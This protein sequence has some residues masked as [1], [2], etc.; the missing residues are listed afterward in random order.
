MENQLL[1]RL[2][3]GEAISGRE[4]LQLTVELSIPAIL[5]QLSSIIM[6]YIDAAMV[7]HLSSYDSAAIG[8][9]SSSTWLLGG[10]CTAGSLGFTV[11]VAH[12]IGAKEGRRARQTVRQ[13]IL[14]NLGIALLL[15]TAGVLVH[16]RLPGWL[17]G[18]EEIRQGAS[19]YFLIFALSL[20]MVILNRLVTGLLQCSGNMKVPSMMHILMCFL[21]VV[22]NALLIFDRLP[23]RLG[24]RTLTLPGAGLGVAGAALG[25]ALAQTCAVAG[26]FYFLF[27]R[28]AELKP[29]RGEKLP[30]SGKI[31]REALRI[32]VPVGVEQA[33]LSSAY[34][35]GTLIVAP[36]GTTAIAANSLSITAESL[37]YMPGYG[38][39][40]AA[41]TLIGQSIGARRTDLTGKIAWMI[42]GL[43]SGIM[44][45]S[46]ALMF[47]AAPLMISL[48]SPDP[49]VQALGAQVLRIE[50]FAE[51]L[52]GASIVATGVLRGA[53]DTL[54][55]SIM[56]LFSMWAVRI[57]LGF[58]LSRFMG[59]A[60]YWTA[61]CTE[62]CVRG[63]IYLLRLRFGRWN[64]GNLS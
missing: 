20:P 9:V 8:L 38:I 2:R 4:L 25:T 21:D 61:M 43:G 32:G 28:S 36:L 64:R 18:A 56:N 16:R 35:A 15:L 42:T 51:P 14:V 27:F 13:G 11:Q 46:G 6:Q 37:C 48:L 54:I 57:P 45:C 50:A 53:G 22:F 58:F 41:T 1:V 5:A 47:L 60:G 39:S 30:F 23:L 33:I 55:P 17:G 29:V 3:D 52:Y 40:T 24:T 49:A 19:A 62:L 10:I 7:G 31:L 63:L 26:M 44:A 34:I 59:L 12:A